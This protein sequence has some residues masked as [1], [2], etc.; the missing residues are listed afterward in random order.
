MEAVWHVTAAHAPAGD[1]GRLPDQ[2]LADELYWDGDA[3][4]LVAALVSSGVL[5]THPVHR[6]VVHGWSEHADSALRHR[7][8]RARTVFWDGMPPF[9]HA[10]TPTEDDVTATDHAVTQTDDD[11]ACG[12]ENLPSLPVPS[13][14]PTPE[15]APTPRTTDPPLAPPAPRV[16][17]ADREVPAGRAYAP[18]GRLPDGREVLDV[19]QAGRPLVVRRRPEGEAGQVAGDA[20]EAVDRLVAFA[21][22]TLGYR[23]DRA[24]RRRLR[25]RLLGGES[26]ARIRAGYEAQLAALEAAEDEAEPEVPA[27]GQTTAGEEDDPELAQALQL[28]A[29]PAVAA[30]Q[31]RGGGVR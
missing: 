10:T 22:E 7:L 14:V 31:G 20:R 27:S 13:P 19:D 26:E 17:T 12:D 4:G 3:E 25:E 21:S 30:A 2:D 15:P 24:A 29:P 18:G 8:K 9:G 11:A 16:G 5:E 6:L 1:I 28:V 23:F